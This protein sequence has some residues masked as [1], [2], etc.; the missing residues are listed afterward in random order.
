MRKVLLTLA[1]APLL[2]SS[3]AFTSVSAN[4]MPL[5]ADVIIQ[6]SPGLLQQVDC[7]RVWRCGFWGCGW[8]EVCWRDRDDW[9]WRD[10]DDWRWRRYH[11]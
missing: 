7:R 1:T 3:V 6:G 11:Y 2:F 5:P 4:A 8:R 10:R 9:R